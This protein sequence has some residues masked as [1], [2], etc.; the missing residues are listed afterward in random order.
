MANTTDYDLE[1]HYA[2]ITG[3]FDPADEPDPELGSEF[4]QKLEKLFFESR[5]SRIAR[6]ILWAYIGGAALFLIG[7]EIVRHFAGVR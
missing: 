6:W 2:D 7:R 4:G 1:R 5:V 3:V